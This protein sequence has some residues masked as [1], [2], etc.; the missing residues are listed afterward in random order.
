VKKSMD[1]YL[2][3]GTICTLKG[4]NKK[5]M[6]T[7][8][9]CV[10]FNGNLKI[11]DYSG[12]TFPEGF[13]LPELNC[14]FN[15]DEIEN[16]DFVGFQNNEQKRFNNLLKNLSGEEKASETEYKSKDGWILES[17]ESYSKLLFDENGVVVLAEPVL[18][19]KSTSTYKFDENGVVT[20][21][22]KNL[23]NPFYKDYS[24]KQSV[25]TNFNDDIFNN[26]EYYESQDG[27]DTI[28]KHK[29]SLTEIKFDE[30]GVVI[31]VNADTLN[32]N[33]NKYKFDENGVLI[34]VEEEEE[35]PPIGPGLPGYEDLKSESKYK[36]DENGV[37]ISVEDEEE[38][39]PVGPGLP[40]YE[41]S[42]SES[43]YKFDENGVL[44]SV[45]EE[46][47]IPPIGPGLPGYEKPKND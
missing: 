42:K 25:K 31:S 4:K 19:K 44:I 10:E 15:H 23:D 43:K 32:D 22:V 1:K 35:I 26:A 30:N 28:G 45:E 3:I 20:K 7:G 14:T 12:C 34:S 24:E 13:L 17:S 11:N 6:I 2:P 27:N 33:F 9:Y 39:P 36:F 18:E 16:V 46:E 29:D 8:Y 38:I 5:V 47:E 21:E 37:L 40:G 41:D